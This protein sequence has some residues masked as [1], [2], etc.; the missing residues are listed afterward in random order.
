MNEKNSSVPPI[1]SIL[2]NKGCLSVMKIQWEYQAHCTFGLPRL[3]YRQ[4]LD[5][6]DYLTIITV[7]LL[8]WTRPVGDYRERITSFSKGADAH[9]Y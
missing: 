4:L 7:I 1:L 6:V 3:C 5:G 8:A 9:R 2:L